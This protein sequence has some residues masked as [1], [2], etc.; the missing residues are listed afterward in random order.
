MKPLVVIGSVPATQTCAAPAVSLRQVLPL[1]LL[2][3][4][5]MLAECGLS[6]Y[7]AWRAKSPALLAF[8]A[9]SFI[10]LL[11]AGVVLL[12]FSRW[13]RISTARAARWSGMLLLA[14][15]GV[16]VCSSLAAIVY[17]FAPE[18]SRMGMAVTIAAL[19]VMPALSWGKRRLARSTGN[20]ALAADAAQSATCAYLAA[21]TLFGLAMN[22]LFHIRWIDPVAALVAI[23]ILWVEAKKALR[24]EPCG[25]C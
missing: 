3:L 10:E 24:G 5:W 25:C 4:C 21:I 13:F 2:T 20:R 14:L 15:G 1:Q 17:G 12:Q 9:D 8:G 11:S 18:S 16:V 22:A 19:V 7:S 23:P 6:L